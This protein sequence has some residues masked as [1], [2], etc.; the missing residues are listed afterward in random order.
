LSKIRMI[1]V[2]Q[3]LPLMVHTTKPFPW[4]IWVGLKI[5]KTNSAYR[6][7][8]NKC[9]PRIQS[10]GFPRPEITKVEIVFGKVEW[11]IWT[12]SRLELKKPQV[13]QTY[14]YRHSL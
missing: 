10:L 8:L 9:S 5:G 12:T 2:L 13:T 7:W 3:D 6:Y 11:S 14:D 1:T 4:V